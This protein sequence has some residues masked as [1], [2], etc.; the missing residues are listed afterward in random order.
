MAPLPDTASARK[1]Q[2]RQKMLAARAAMNPRARM[3]ADEALVQRLQKWLVNTIGDLASPVIAA[4]TPA[5]DEPGAS[6]STAGDDEPGRGFVEAIASA[7]PGA[8]ILLPV[9]PPGA[10][11]PL[12]WGYFDEVLLKGRFGLLEPVS[13]ENAAGPDELGAADAIILPAL[14]A[15]L[16]TGM[17]LGRGAGYYDRSLTF[18]RREAATSGRPAAAIA[19]VVFDTELQQG[20][21]YDSHDVPADYVITSER[22]TKI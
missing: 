1:S 8:R 7:L 5:G 15:D 20:L 4:Y 16:E 11:Q 22:T 10:P 3:L 13:V 2:T 6:F 19:V 17:R 21:A 9:C 18:A 14:A 12:H